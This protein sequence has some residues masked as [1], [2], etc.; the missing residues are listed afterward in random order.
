M[1]GRTAGTGFKKIS[2]KPTDK[3]KYI[4]FSDAETSRQEVDEDARK[5][6]MPDEA[7]DNEKLKLLGMKRAFNDQPPALD[8]QDFMSVATS[9]CSKR[10]LKEAGR[11]LV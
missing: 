5:V 6:I 7:S 2:V 4:L 8:L 3:R 9:Q 1:A 11:Q 10:K